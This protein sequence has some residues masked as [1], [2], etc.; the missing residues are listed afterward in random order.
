MPQVD[1]FCTL[2][3]SGEL[4]LR[5]SHQYY[6]QIQGQMAIGECPWCDFVVYTSKGASVQRVAFNSNFWS[7][8]LLPKLISFYDSCILPELVSP[9][10]LQSCDLMSTS[11]TFSQEEAA[12][13]YKTQKE[14][15]GL[16]CITALWIAS[17]F[18]EKSSILEPSPLQDSLS[19]PWQ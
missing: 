3:A 17:C 11:Q 8:K 19:T 6:A 4:K 2:E 15:A 10:H 5:E 12:A 7:D 16:S 13:C 9:V 14:V 1:F 18:R